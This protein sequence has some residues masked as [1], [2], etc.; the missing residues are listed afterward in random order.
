MIEIALLR[1]FTLNSHVES[2]NIFLILES[3]RSLI[4]SYTHYDFFNE[5]NSFDT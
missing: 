3:I 4:V 5:M 2:E 1:D